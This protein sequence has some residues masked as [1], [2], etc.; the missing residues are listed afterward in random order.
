MY[1][2]MRKIF[3]PLIALAVL[4]GCD[5]NKQPYSAISPENALSS[6]AD[7]SKL[8]NFIYANFR[9]ITSG[10]YIYSGEIQSDFFNAS[11]EYG[12]NGGDLHRWN[13]SNNLGSSLTFWS[14]TYSVSANDNFFIKKINDYM[15]AQR[16]AGTLSSED[17]TTLMRYK[18]EAFFSRAYAYFLS[19]QYMCNDYDPSTAANE[20]GLPIVLEYNPTSDDSQ[21]PARE[22]L[23]RT[24]EQINADLDSAQAYIDTEADGD[25]AI[26]F[27]KD[28][29]AAFRARVA[30]YMDD[31]Q[32]A[33]NYAKPLVDMSIA[34][35]RY[36]L[37]TDTA[38]FNPLWRNDTGDE[39]IMQVFSSY[40]E[41]PSS[42]SYNYV[43]YSTALGTYRPYYIPT[44]KVID[45][46]D[47][48]DIRFQSWFINVPVT[49]TGVSA[50]VYLCN[51]Y[52]GNPDLWVGE[53]NYRNAPKPF[54]IAEQYLILAEAYDKA[55]NETEAS[56]ILNTLQAA[57]IPSHSNVTYVGLELENEI[58]N[59]RIRELFAEG[60]RL[61]DLK[62]YGEG[63][64]GRP[65]QSSDVIFLPGGS[66][67]EE[68]IVSGDSYR[69]TWPIPYEEMI[70][71]PQIASQQNAGY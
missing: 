25:G 9:G 55:G 2:K 49:F 7:A 68:I 65:A 51:K 45:L 39:C 22:S 41:Q 14:A 70:T 12:N 28:A 27:T 29:V 52:P 3:I 46:Y 4:T 50:T 10:S 40:N 63:F 69:F 71:N 56:N 35:T 34:G 18:G 58:K 42:S 20:Y 19:A 11:L 61:I 8:R 67:T 1:S 32:S 59:E 57:R 37:L 64:E 38:G 47:P 21:Y 36:A 17:S 44:Q 15:A 23:Q 60:F 31:Y 54:R 62:R 5:M 13:F 6:M 24:F 16:S 33:I 43:A 48:Q 66:D 26:Y 30:L 53:T